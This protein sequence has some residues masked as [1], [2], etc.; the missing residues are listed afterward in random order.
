MKKLLILC[1][2]CIA[3]CVSLQK[4]CIR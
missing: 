3:S 1:Y 2:C 4:G